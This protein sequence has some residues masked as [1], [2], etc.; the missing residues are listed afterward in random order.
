MINTQGPQHLLSSEGMV[1]H[2]TESR[3]SNVVI[4]YKSVYMFCSA[5]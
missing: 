5:E 3:P 1:G 4:D 2:S